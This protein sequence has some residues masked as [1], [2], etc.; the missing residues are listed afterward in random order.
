MR[1]NSQEGLE[2][3]VGSHGKQLA[4]LGFQLGIVA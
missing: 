3:G 1:F 4:Y 2:E